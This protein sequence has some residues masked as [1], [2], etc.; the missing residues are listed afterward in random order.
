MVL[1][2]DAQWA[3]LCHHLARP[4]LARLTRADRRGERLVELVAVVSEWCAARTTAECL[5]ALADCDLPAGAVEPPWVGRD[6]PHVAALGSLE[7]LRHGASGEA[8]GFLGPRL[9]FRIDGDDDV[10][11]GTDPAEPLGTSTDAVLRDLCGCDDDELT[12][13]RRDGVIG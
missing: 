6:D 8:T 3:K 10:D 1:T 11:L 4:D 9:P 2:D 5:A 13:L 7:P 12:R